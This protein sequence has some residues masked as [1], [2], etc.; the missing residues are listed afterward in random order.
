LIIAHHSADCTS[1]TGFA[2]TN[3][4]ADQDTAAFVEVATGELNGFDLKR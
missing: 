4:V 2:E 3:Y 1:N